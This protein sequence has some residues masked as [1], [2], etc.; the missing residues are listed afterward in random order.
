MENNLNNE[1]LKDL[2]E[3]YEIELTDE[4]LESI[5]GGKRDKNGLLIQ[6]PYFTFCDNFWPRYDP[7]QNDV[8]CAICEYEL[9]KYKGG[10][11]YNYC[12]SQ[13]V[14]NFRASIWGYRW[15]N[16]PLK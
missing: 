2:M 8:S 7:T 1:Q 10:L 3:K 14:R 11:E 5:T 4:Q 9:W 16:N 12:T 15:P 6:F 13:N